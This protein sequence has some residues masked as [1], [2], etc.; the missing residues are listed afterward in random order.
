MWAKI[1]RNNLKSNLRLNLNLSYILY[2]L[3]TITIIYLSILFQLANNA[4]ALTYQNESSIDFTI[5]PTISI[6]LSSSS[7]SIDDLAPGSYADSNIIT[8]TA[9]SNAVAGYSLTSTVGVTTNASNELRKDGTNTTNKFTSLTTNQSTLTGFNDNEWGYSYSICSTPECTNE[10]TWISGNTGSTLAGYD[11]YDYNTTT[12]TSETIT[13]LTTT[14]SGSS[15]IKYKIGAKSSAAQLAGEYTNAI[16]FIGVAN[17]NPEPIYMQDITL[18]QCQRN[19]GAN[20]NPENIGDNITVVDRRDNNVYTVRYINGQCWMTQ[21]LR[22]TGII[23]AE[24]SNFT[25]NNFNVSEYSLD[26]N[27]STYVNHCDVNG[28]NY[29]CSKVST[30]TTTGAWYNYYAA[31]AGTISGSSNITP[32]TQDIC[33][34]N[35]HLPGGPNTI[36][37]TDINKLVGNTTSG[38]QPATSNLMAFEA[39][40]GGLYGY[41]LGEITFPER[42][43]WWTSTTSTV[44]LSDYRFSINYNSASNTFWGDDHNARYRGLFVRCVRSS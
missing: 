32:A 5:N 33:P 40:P 36:A 21:N 25:G 43:H 37:G 27:D 14:T 13:H 29:A 8:I 44:S 38:W 28:Y 35:W 17:P 11:G 2:I 30:N 12:S 39:V 4:S 1:I 7:L 22:I 26:A 23:P 9:S 42:G 16:N 19:V 10:P 34:I 24:R 31:T 41:V 15:A 18:A 3:S 20:G 6:T